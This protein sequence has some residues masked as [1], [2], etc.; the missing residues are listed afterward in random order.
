MVFFPRESIGMRCL[1]GAGMKK[2]GL[3]G[4]AKEITGINLSALVAEKG[5][6][7]RARSDRLSGVAAC[8]RVDG[9]LRRKG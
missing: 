2:T 9:G 1:F 7:R 5:T 8:R 3:S 6:R 4:Q